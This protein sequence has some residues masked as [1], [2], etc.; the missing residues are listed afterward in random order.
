MNKLRHDLAFKLSV[1][2]GCSLETGEEL[3]DAIALYVLEQAGLRMKKQRLERETEE[4][5]KE[6][7]RA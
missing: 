4:V 5:E 6:I 3:A 7:V 2:T 1:A